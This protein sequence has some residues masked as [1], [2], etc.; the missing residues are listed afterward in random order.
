MPQINVQLSLPNLQCPS[1]LVGALSGWTGSGEGE[2]EFISAGEC[3]RCGFNWPLWFTPR[4]EQG[5]FIGIRSV[6]VAA[7]TQEGEVE[8]PS[9]E[10]WLRVSMGLHLDAFYRDGFY[11]TDCSDCKAEVIAFRNETKSAEQAIVPNP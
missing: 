9:C 7:R 5:R 8:C 11:S 6:L 1:C 2:V 3:N 10:S 4:L